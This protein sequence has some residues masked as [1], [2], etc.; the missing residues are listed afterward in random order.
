MLLS[1][2]KAYKNSINY[3]DPPINNKPHP[4]ETGQGNYKKA[5]RKPFA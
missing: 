3:K 5:M 2:L 1:R 4:W